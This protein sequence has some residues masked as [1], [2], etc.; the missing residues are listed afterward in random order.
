MKKIILA[1]DSFKGSVNSIDIAD[2]VKGAIL[3]EYPHCNVVTFPIADGGE[4]TIEAICSKLDVV[5]VNC[6]AHDPLMNSINVEYAITKDGYTAI[7]EMA[8]ASGLPLVPIER[9]NP[10]NTTTYGT[11]EIIFDALQRG[12]RKFIMGIGGSATNDAGIGLLNA[13]GIRF[14]DKNKKEL[15]PIGGNLINID[16]IDCSNVVLGLNNAMFI[17]VCDVNNPFT[18]KEGAAYVYAPQ[19]GASPIEVEKLNNGM[20]H[21]AKILKNIKGTDIVDI[22]GAGAAGGMGGGLLPFLN[23]TL[24]PGIE[25]IL[26]MLKFDEAIK[27]ANLVLTGEGK[28][29]AQTNMGKALG[30]IVKKA[31][32]ADVPVIAICGCVEDIA[33]LNEMGFTAVLPIQPAPVSLEKAMQKQFALD[34]IVR[35]VTQIIRIVKRFE[36]VYIM[37]THK[38]KKQSQNL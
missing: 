1:F 23:A 10:M 35:T 17:I 20:E 5:R 36:N 19:K 9:R 29:D 24:K 37:S 21:Y 6:M 28:L 2:S 12:C 33:E 22:P 38:I 18:G 30:G 15:L 8:T 31:K 7:L 25:T 27:D 4:G 16:C 11:G 34:N 32:I 26:D 13:L 3:L 14:L